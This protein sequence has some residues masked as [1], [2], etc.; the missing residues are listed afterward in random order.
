[1]FRTYLILLNLADGRVRASVFV[2]EKKKQNKTNSFILIKNPLFFFYFYFFF[3]VRKITVLC[4]CDLCT[5]CSASQRITRSLSKC[6]RFSDFFFFFIHTVI[7]VVITSWY[8]GHLTNTLRK[9]LRGAR[10]SCPPEPWRCCWQA[11]SYSTV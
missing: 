10:S 8:C 3:R 6:R 1:M 11:Y 9:W 2:D 5:K 4:Y 7:V